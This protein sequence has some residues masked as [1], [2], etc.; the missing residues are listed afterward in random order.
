M[1]LHFSQTPPLMMSKNRPQT[2]QS[3]L[4]SV[5]RSHFARLNT[6]E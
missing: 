6:S 3:V 5:S 4:T 2:S 1:R